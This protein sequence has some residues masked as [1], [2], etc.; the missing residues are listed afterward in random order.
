MNEREMVTYV[1]L[2]IL[3]S[4]IFSSTVEFSLQNRITRGDIAIDLIRPVHLLG[5]YLAE[6]AG[7]AISAFISRL[8]PLLVIMIL[9]IQVPAPKSLACFGLSIVSTVLGFLILWFISALV[10]MLCFWYVQLGNLGAVKDGFILLLSG[11]IIP[12]WLFPKSAQAVLQ[13]FPFQHIYQTP[14]SV[15]IGLAEPGEIVRI[16]LIQAAWA[17]FLGGLANGV[18]VRAKKRVQILG[19]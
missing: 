8:I 4:A 18:L 10:A 5:I 6:D 13:Y 11:K 9:F 17:L 3:L 1:L 12:L 16:L 2:T 15:Y 7:L 14:V 19:G